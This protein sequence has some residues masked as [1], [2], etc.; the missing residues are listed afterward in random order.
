MAGIGDRQSHAVAVVFQPDTDVAAAGGVAHRVGNQVR[1]RA[2]Q[3]GGRAAQ[4]HAEPVFAVD[5]VL[6]T[7]QG[8]GFAFQRKQH[9]CQSHAFF[10]QALLCFQSRDRQQIL[11]D[12]GH[13]LRLAAHFRQDR[14]QCRAVVLGEQFQIA[15]DHGQRSAQFVRDIGDEITPHL[16]QPGQAGD[17]LGH[18]QVLLRGKRDQPQQQAPLRIDR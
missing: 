17:V 9:R 13:A 15:V 6:A 3:I 5:L 10:R 8:L 1:K 4:I 7:A 2:V 11:D 14:L 18:Q 16:F 12:A